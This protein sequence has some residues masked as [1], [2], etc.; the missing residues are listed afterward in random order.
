MQ[1]AGINIGYGY[2]KM[3]T[4]SDY[5]Q[6]A[7]VVEKTRR[8]SMGSVGAT[9]ETV[10]VVVDNEIY[11]I[12]ADA[13]QLS[14]TQNTSKAVSDAWYDTVQY[15]ALMQLVIDRLQQESES[16]GDNQWVITLGIAVNQYQRQKIRKQLAEIWKGEH[17][18]SEGKKIKV[19]KANVVPE[20]LGAYTDYKENNIEDTHQRKVLII[21]PGYR[22]TDWI[23]VCDSKIVERH[24]DAIDQGMFDVY[25]EVC[26]SIANDHD[27]KLDIVAVEQSILLHREIRVRGNPVDTQIYYEAALKTIGRTIESRLRTEIGAADHIDLIVVAGGGG[28]AMLKFIKKSFPKHQI[29][30]CEN[31]QEANA[32]GYYISAKNFTAMTG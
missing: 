2:L 20:P 29:V 23:E 8:A 16:D 28:S 15:R 4:K 11:E 17:L 22:T 24:A 7:S 13:H 30:I 18:S 21:D 6:I 10:K 19:T 12:G 14:A 32:R 25:S 5:F 3:K 27:A 9:R 1:A 26:R 31:P